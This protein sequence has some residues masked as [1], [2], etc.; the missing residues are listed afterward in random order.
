MNIRRRVLGL[1][2]AS[3]LVVMPLLVAACAQA[4][5]TADGD[6]TP[7][8]GTS[9]TNPTGADASASASA[10]ASID[11]R[12]PAVDAGVDARL[13][14]RADTGTGTGTVID[15]GRDAVAEASAVDAGIDA[16]IDAGID[17]STG[18]TFTSCGP[19]SACVVGVCTPARRT[20]LSSTSQTAGMGGA[21]GADAI[22]QNLAT[23]AH[24]GGTWMAWL[25]DSSSNTPS[26]RMT[27]AT[28]PYRLIDGTYVAPDWNGLASAN[29]LHGIDLDEGGAV[30]FGA[31]VWTGS[32]YSGAS[33]TPGCNGFT[34]GTSSAPYANVGISGHTDGTW[35]S[36][37][38]QFCDRNDRLCCIE[39]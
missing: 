16:S 8:S 10:D 9:T 31:E 24:L 14:A 35:S 32:S 28:I 1:S 18:C 6:G 36:T 23:Q 20:F 7:D 19:Q 22:C 12:A 21:A 26:A 27:H 38:S 37:Y 25:S 5:D 33:A 39:Q 3:A 13:D 29:L 11:H 34:Q 30:G 15:S 2:A 4:N 17:T